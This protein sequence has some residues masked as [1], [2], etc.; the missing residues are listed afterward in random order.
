MT[1]GKYVAINLVATFLAFVLTTPARI[2][3]HRY[4]VCHIPIADKRF[5]SGHSRNT[6]NTKIISI[7][8]NRS[9]CNPNDVAVFFIDS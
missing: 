4:I 6:I 2:S 7:T 1:S 9:K 5:V 3:I 8:I